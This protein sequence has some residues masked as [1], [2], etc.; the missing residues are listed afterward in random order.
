[1]EGVAMVSAPV[2]P[3]ETPTIACRFGATPLLAASQFGSSSARKVSHC[4]LPSA[5]QFV[6]ML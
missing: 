2:P 1:M 5:S 4:L 6:Y 3:W